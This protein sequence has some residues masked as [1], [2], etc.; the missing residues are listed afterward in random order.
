MRNLSLGKLFPQLVCTL[1][2]IVNRSREAPRL[3]IDDPASDSIR[4]PRLERGLLPLF[5][6]PVLEIL[7]A[8]GHVC[9]DALFG[10]P[11]HVLRNGAINGGIAVIH[12]LSPLPGAPSEQTTTAA[13]QGL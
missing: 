7:L 6:D 12:K 10:D 3:D 4:K 1:E 8:A 11:I 13:R 9:V 5:R 2:R